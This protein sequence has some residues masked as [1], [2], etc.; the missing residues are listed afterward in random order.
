[1]VR[2]LAERWGWATSIISF[3][4]LCALNA[5]QLL[6]LFGFRAAA[7]TPEWQAGAELVL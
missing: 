7:P 5:A 2:V 3:L 6:L 1:M 4:I